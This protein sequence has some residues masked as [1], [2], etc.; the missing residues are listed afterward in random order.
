L[1]FSSDTPCIANVIPAM[2]RMHADLV[3]ACKNENYSTAIRAALEIG[4]KLLDKYYS[5]T[6]NSEVYRIAMSKSFFFYFLGTIYLI[7]CLVLHPAHKL[8]YFSKQGWDKAW[9]DTAEEI[10]RDEFKRNYAAYVVN[11]GV[12]ASRT[13]KVSPTLSVY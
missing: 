1:E 9:I 2:D 5:I 13:P 7:S 11:K 10:V 12:K 4:K 8:K 3:A 6:D